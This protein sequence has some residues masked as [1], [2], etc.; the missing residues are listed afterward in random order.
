MD[1]KT[2]KRL[3]AVE[4]DILM[5]FDKFCHDHKIQYSLFAGTALGAVRH[6]GFIPW[7]DDVDIFMD[8]KN[9]DRFIALWR[10]YPIEG[11]YLQATDDRNNHYNHTKIRKDGTILAS[12]SEMKSKGHHGI[13][14]DIFPFYKVPINRKKRK[15]FNMNAYVRILCTR[16]HIPQKANLFVKVVALIFYKT[17]LPVK[18]K[19]KNRTEKRL[20]QFDDLTYEFEYED[21]SAAIWMNKYYPGN[22]FNEFTSIEFAG[23]NFQI[24]GNYKKMLEIKYGDYMQLPPIE[25]RVCRH[26]PEVVDFG[27]KN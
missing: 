22:M 7:D 10:K 27:N 8:L 19:I 1:E 15:L 4:L 23:H 3:Q 17:P 21:I 16:N 2:L 12:N 6:K 11:Y 24:I 18:E 20:R 14:I 26:N 13:W 9:Y 5:V 25:E